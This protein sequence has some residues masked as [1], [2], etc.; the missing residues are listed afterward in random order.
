MKIERIQSFTPL[1]V[2]IDSLEEA[3]HLRNILAT[4]VDGNEESHEALKLLRLEVETAITA[5][6]EQITLVEARRSR[7]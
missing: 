6:G 2:T 3:R 4:M 5:T 1:V 7:T